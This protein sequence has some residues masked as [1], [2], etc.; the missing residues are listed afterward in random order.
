MIRRQNGRH[1]HLHF[2][3]CEREGHVKN[4]CFYFKRVN[5]SKLSD[6]SRTVQSVAM[7]EPATSDDQPR[8]AFMAGKI[9]S[10]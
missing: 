8:F 6:R 1:I 5:K 10:Q 4:D 2:S 9:D 7:T 3:N